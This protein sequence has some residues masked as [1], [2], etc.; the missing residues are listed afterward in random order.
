MSFASSIRSKATSAYECYVTDIKV[1]RLMPKIYV[2][3]IVLE[4]D[5]F[6]MANHEII[7]GFNSFTNYEWETR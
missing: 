5:I 6:S 4:N 7:H 1:D 3:Q 2:N